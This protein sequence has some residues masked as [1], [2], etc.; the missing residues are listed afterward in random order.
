MPSWNSGVLLITRYEINTVAVDW[1]SCSRASLGVFAN[2]EKRLLAS[3]CLSFHPSGC[4]SASSN[5]APTGQNFTK[6]DI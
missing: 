5:S 4:P 3:S 1:I 2:Y 6:F